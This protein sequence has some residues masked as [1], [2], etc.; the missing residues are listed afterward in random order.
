[1]HVRAFSCIWAAV[2]IFTAES[3]W[4]ARAQP[5]GGLNGS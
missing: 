2:A 1:V 5:P 3:W 4:R